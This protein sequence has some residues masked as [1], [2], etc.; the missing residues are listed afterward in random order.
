MNRALWLNGNYYYRVS[1]FNCFSYFDSKLRLRFLKQ[2]SLYFHFFFSFFHIANARDM[3]LEEIKRLQIERYIQPAD[4]TKECGKILFNEI[5]IPLKHEYVTK[6]ATDAVCGHHLTCLLKLNNT[7]H[8]IA[9]KTIP[10]LP[11]LLAA[12]FPD[13]LKLN[14]VSADFS[15]R[16]E[17]YGMAVQRDPIP[18]DNKYQ[19]KCKKVLALLTPKR[20][21][22]KIHDSTN[23]TATFSPSTNDLNRKSSF[24]LLGYVDITL[25]DLN[26]IHFPMQIIDNGIDSMP[27]SGIISMKIN[28]EHETKVEYR[29]FLTIFDDVS[30]YGAWNR[31]WCYLCNNKINYWLYPDDEQKQSLGQFDLK[32]CKQ[33]KISIVPREICARQ[34]T[35]M[36]E[37]RRPSLPNDTNSLIVTKNN[38]ETIL[39]HLF[40]CDTKEERDEWIIKLNKALLLSRVWNN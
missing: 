36:I 8:V 27:L 38:D 11:G 24:V 32:L 10:T 3:A 35:I 21:K 39:R 4:L 20:K 16:M 29:G 40:S 23:L 6:L 17:I 13:S 15:A 1:N 14:D 9:T 7:E 28:S 34:N 37:L 18:I 2:I 5:T 22:G 30:G 25:N 19:M 12:K 31:R 33:E 26:R